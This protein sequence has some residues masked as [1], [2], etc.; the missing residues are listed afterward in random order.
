MLSFAQPL[1]AQQA[2]AKVAKAVLGIVD[3][4][5]SEG[6]FFRLPYEFEWECDWLT[7]SQTSNPLVAATNSL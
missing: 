5:P 2:E 1:H 4:K 3:E 6:Q 7:T